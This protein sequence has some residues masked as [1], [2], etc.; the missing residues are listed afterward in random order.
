MTLINSK[1]EYFHCFQTLVLVESEAP[2]VMGTDIE[3]TVAVLSMKMIDV[4]PAA[5]AHTVVKD[6]ATT[7]E[8]A[9]DTIVVTAIGNEEI[10]VRVLTTNL[11]TTRSVVN[12][13]TSAGET[14]TATVREID[15]TIEA[16][17]ED[18]VQR[19]TIADV[20]HLRC[21]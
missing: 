3:V 18:H 6:P 8:T 4:D 12:K 10:E 7:V 13:T 21:Q 17:V 1:I 19:I 16:I 2:V 14:D 11:M 15:L 20:E 5:V 9:V